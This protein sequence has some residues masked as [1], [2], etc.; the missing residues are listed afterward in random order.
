MPRVPTNSLELHTPNAPELARTSHSSRK[1]QIY[2]S[3]HELLD[4]GSHLVLPEAPQAPLSSP[5]FLEIPDAPRPFLL[6]IKL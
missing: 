1:H 2:P 6:A 4:A 3:F 5:Y